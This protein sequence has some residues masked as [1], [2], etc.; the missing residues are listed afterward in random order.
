MLKGLSSRAAEIS[1]SQMPYKIFL[2]ISPG[3]I[4]TIYSIM[5]MHTVIKMNI[6]P[7]FPIDLLKRKI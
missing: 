1:F 5:S 4:A 7:L 3:F 2:E 6:I